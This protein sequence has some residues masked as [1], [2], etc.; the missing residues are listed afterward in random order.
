MCY[1]RIT[2]FIFIH[3][4]IN[5]LAYHI[6]VQ[7]TLL[8]AERICLQL[9]TLPNLPDEVKQVVTG[10]NVAVMTPDAERSNPFQA[11]HRA[12]QS[13]VVINENGSSAEGPSDEAG[14][15]TALAGT[16]GAEKAETALLAGNLDDEH[17]ND[18]SIV[19]NDAL[20]DDVGAAVNEQP[21]NVEEPSS[22]DEIVV[23]SEEEENIF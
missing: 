11:P 18:L 5:D 15:S 2:Q 4:Y 6:D 17:T 10:K 9:L 3:Q 21:L 20:R 22:D 13:L 1:S 14:T 7:E 19:T 8:T 16:E 12:L 23:L